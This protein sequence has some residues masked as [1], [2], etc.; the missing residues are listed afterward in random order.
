MVI[1]SSIVNSRSHTVWIA[2]PASWSPWQHSA[3]VWNCVSRFGHTRLDQS[4][5][6][7]QWRK[8]VKKCDKVQFCVSVQRIWVI[9][10][11]CIIVLLWFAEFWTVGLRGYT[12]ILFSISHHFSPYSAVILRQKKSHA[13]S[14]IFHSTVYPSLQSSSQKSQI[15]HCE[16]LG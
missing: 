7:P 3:L 12:V 13:Y 16:N 10:H 6:R 1:Q 8:S 2:D 5:A 11:V 9:W 15:S 14:D 4:T